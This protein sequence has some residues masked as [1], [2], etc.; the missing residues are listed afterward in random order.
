MEHLTPEGIKGEAGREHSSFKAAQE[1]PEPFRA[2]PAD[3]KTARQFGNYVRGHMVP[4]ADMKASQEAMDATFILNHNVVPQD[5]VCNSAAWLG[6][7][8]LVRKAA[9]KQKH[10][11]SLTGPVFKPQFNSETGQKEVTYSLVGAHDVAVPTHLFKVILSEGSDGS[12][13]TAAFLVPNSPCDEAPIAYKVKK[14]EIE[15][16]TGLQLFDKLD[17][18]KGV[19]DL[20]GVEKCTDKARAFGKKKEE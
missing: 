15:R 13:Y 11:W 19:K 6:L 16:L 1:V 3:Y 7:E 20:C 12:V 18:M 5:G 14:E 4:A 8:S 17:A 10:T 9:K 2:T